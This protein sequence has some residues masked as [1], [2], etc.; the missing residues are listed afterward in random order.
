MT[1]EQNVDFVLRTV[2]ERDIRFVQFW[3]TDLLGNLKSFAIS[4][5]DLE[6]AFDEG[7]GFDGFAVDGFAP[8]EESDML[9]FPDP[10]TFQILPWRP[11]ERG[12]ARVICSILTPGGE[13][14][15]GDSRGCLMK[16][17]EATEEKG[18]LFNAGPELEYFF[19]D[20]PTMPAAAP[21][22]SAGYFDLTPSDL[23]RDLRR[24]TTLMLEHMSIP[25]EYSFHANAPSQ[26]CVELRY[27]EAV[28]CADAIMTARLVIRQ[29]AQ[30]ND[31]LDQA[32]YDSGTN[33]E[34]MEYLY[35]VEGQNT[36]VANALCSL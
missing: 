30:A 5:E 3:F 4:P 23:A 12:A 32:G 16:A 8:L 18:Y 24:E 36:A 22:D 20:G 14:F 17:F 10:S 11:S 31:L 26:N 7:I 19:F 28:S 15:E 6:E 9:A 25:V 2:E 33:L 13:Q 27:S 1:H 35:V 21:I 34:P 29:V